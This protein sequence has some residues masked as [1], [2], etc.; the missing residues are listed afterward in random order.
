VI[1]GVGPCVFFNLQGLP[2]NALS[3]S[4]AVA[5]SSFPEGQPLPNR[6]IATETDLCREVFD[7]LMDRDL[8]GFLLSSSHLRK[9][10]AHY[11]SYA[12]PKFAEPVKRNNAHSAVVDAFHQKL[13]GMFSGAY[14]AE[15]AIKD[16]DELM[17]TLEAKYEDFASKL[18]SSYVLYEPSLK[19]LES[20]DL[21]WR[22][23]NAC[24]AGC[25]MSV[26]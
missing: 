22:Y 4:T 24:G 25:P 23:R 26:I 19:Q 8:L 12:E 3:T 10:L 5:T 21:A 17:A 11:P 7:D 6:G 16:R 13:L 9:Y 1:S 18:K 14:I 15:A 20:V 2:M